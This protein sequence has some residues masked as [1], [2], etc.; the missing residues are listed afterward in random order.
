MYNASEL[1]AHRDRWYEKVKNSHGVMSN[2]DYINLDRKLFMEIREILPSD[3]GSI[4][5]LRFHDYGGSFP[6]GAHDDLTNFIRCCVKPEFEFIDIDLEGARTK[7]A[8]AIDLFLNTINLLTYPLDGG[9]QDK[10]SVPKE[11]SYGSKEQKREYKKSIYRLNELKTCVHQAYDEL[12]RL[13]RRK[14]A[15]G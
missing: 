8:N 9:I 15:C 2:P 7:L 3:K 4:V 14:L 12:I 6:D 11:W 10:Y 1:K 5:Y 13:G